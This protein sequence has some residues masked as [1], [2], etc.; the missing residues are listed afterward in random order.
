MLFDVGEASAA[1]FVDECKNHRLRA[2]KTRMCGRSEAG[3]LQETARL[4]RGL[5]SILG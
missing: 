1:H 4:K 5:S 3:L 2:A